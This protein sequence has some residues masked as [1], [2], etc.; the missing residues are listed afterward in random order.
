MARDRALKYYKDIVRLKDKGSRRKEK[1][2]R[3]KVVGFRL[4]V[5]GKEVM[6]C[7]RCAVLELLSSLGFLSYLG[8]S[9]LLS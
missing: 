5:G 2:E 8:L 3:T 9:G 1:G 6:Q 4:E 7:C